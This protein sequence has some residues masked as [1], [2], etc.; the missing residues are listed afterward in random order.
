MAIQFQP[1]QRKTLT[2]VGGQK[3]PHACFGFGAWWFLEAQDEGTVEMWNGLSF[4]G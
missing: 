3:L 2:S 4:G 1:F